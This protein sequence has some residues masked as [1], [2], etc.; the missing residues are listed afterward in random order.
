L[1]LFTTQTT[2]DNVLTCGLI[3]HAMP[4]HH[5]LE[6]YLAAYL[7]GAGL[8]DDPKRALFPSLHRA[9]AGPSPAIQCIRLMRT[10]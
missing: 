1:I 7:D 5:N 2:S 10:P 3:G 8:R 6:E 9:P 4:C